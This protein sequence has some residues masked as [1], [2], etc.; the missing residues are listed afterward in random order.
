MQKPTRTQ[1][2]AS[3]ALGTSESHENF[4]NPLVGLLDVQGHEGVLCGVAPCPM[5]SRQREKIVV[6]APWL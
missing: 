5:Q 2:N 6:Y 4:G 1:E 3:E